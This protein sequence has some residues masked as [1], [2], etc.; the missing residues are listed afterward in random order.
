MSK[1]KIISC[2]IGA[3]VIGGAAL[4]AGL[5]SAAPNDGKFH[6]DYIKKDVTAP[7]GTKDNV[8]TVVEIVPNE[9]FGDF[10][11]LIPGC[12]PI[13]MNKLAVSEDIT[14]YTNLFVE[15]PN[16]ELADEKIKTQRRFT[17]A[18]MPTDLVDQYDTEN[19]LLLADGLKDAIDAAPI[20]ITARN[21]GITEI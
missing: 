8:F 5:T 11:Y 20:E 13:D 9:A 18:L 15:G 4:F 14:D 6:L 2:F 1:K 16:G 7:L 17:D 10:G 19:E 12:E 21:Y 3:V